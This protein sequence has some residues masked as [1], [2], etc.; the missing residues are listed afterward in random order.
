MTELRIDPLSGLRV[1]VAG[2]RG[3]RPGAWLDVAPRAPIDRERDP[4]AEG[5]EDQ[6]PPEV[7]ALRDNG[8]APN[9]A[10]WRVR[11]V[12][13]LFPAL[14]PGEPEPKQDPLAGGRGEPDLF[15]SQP[16]LGAHEVIINAPDPVHSLAEV[17]PEQV[18]AAMGVWRERMR[19]HSGAAYLHLIVNEGKE[20]GASLPHTHAQLYALPFVPA[21]VARER[22]RFTAYADRT[23]GRNLLEDIVQE[24]VR[25]RE[26]IVAI[27]DEAVA[28]C[29]FGARV[30]FHMQVVPRRPSARFADDGPLGARMLHEALA[31]LGAVLRGLPPLNMWVRTAPR[32]A[33]RFC[34]RIDVMPRLA[35]L[36]GLE[37]GTGVHLNV[38]APED[39]AERLRDATL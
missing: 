7:Y 13:N 27:D 2:E 6:T 23:Q 5:H 4:F 11:V 37:I 39:A 15:A 31:R 35:Q 16:A 24:E 20:A 26:R 14:S 34:W 17:P 25:R 28:L 38:L 32:D 29:P 3:R 19:E 10:G 36:A 8:G 12:P 1:I 30:P 18:E 33:E 22:E 21:A 9:G